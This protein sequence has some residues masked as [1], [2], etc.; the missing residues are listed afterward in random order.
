MVPLVKQSFFQV[1]DAAW[2][3]TQPSASILYTKYIWILEPTIIPDYEM[4]YYS[5]TLSK[6]TAYKNSLIGFQAGIFHERQIECFQTNKIAT[7]K[8]VDMIHGAWFLPSSWLFVLKQ[9]VNAKALDLPLA[10]FISSSLLYKRN[11]SSVVIPS[12]L[13]VVS[14]PS[15]CSNWNDAVRYPSDKFHSVLPGITKTKKNVYTVGVG[16]IGTR[17]WADA[18][19]L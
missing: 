3:V 6:T 9:E 11:V 1:R 13:Q 4:L 7:A 17:L 12:K 15:F 8:Q 10:Y 19:D 2:L 18:T 14:S 16:F 5:Y